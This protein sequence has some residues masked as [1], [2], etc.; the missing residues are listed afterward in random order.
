MDQKIKVILGRIEDLRG[1]LYETAA[2][3]NFKDPE[4]L[5]ISREIDTKMN[6]YLKIIHNKNP[7]RT[8]QGS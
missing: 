3:R 7:D 4:V 6:A 1:Q 5:A 2:H 8:S